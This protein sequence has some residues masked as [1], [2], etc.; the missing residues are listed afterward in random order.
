M[1]ELAKEALAVNHQENTLVSHYISYCAKNYDRTRK[2][3]KQCTIKRS[4]QAIGTGRY[5]R[6][7]V[8]MTLRPAP[9]GSGIVFRRVD[10][11]PIVVLTLDVAFIQATIQKTSLIQGSIAVHG[12]EHLISTLAGLGLSNLYVDINQAELP[13]MDGS[14]EPFVF[15]IQSA[16]IQ[17][18]S[19]LKQFIRIREKVTVTTPESWVTISPSATLQ[20]DCTL[21]TDKL[22]ELPQQYSMTL[23]QAVYSKLLSRARHGADAMPVYARRYPNEGIRHHLLDTIG[24]L[25]LLGYPILGSMKS[26]NTNHQLNYQLLCELL[27]NPETW[28]LIAYPLQ[29][30]STLETIY[31]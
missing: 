13:M 27:A 5:S 23:S 21:P 14:T 20:I 18:Q 25:Y 11:Q 22:S 12:I 31:Y 16:G 26:Y 6:K 10:T 4:V 2:D 8:T 24:D 17:W 1:I 29:A 7:P 19:A 9:I 30:H 15:L 3:F 28:E